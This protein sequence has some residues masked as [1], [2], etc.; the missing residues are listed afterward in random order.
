MKLLTDI[1]AVLAHART[2]PDVTPLEAQ[3]VL[4][5]LLG[6]ERSWIIAHPEA[7][8]TEDQ[9]S[10]AAAMLERLAQ[11]EPL[12]YLT[13]TRAFYGLDFAITPDVL[14][15]R[16]D[17]ETLVDA[18]LDWARQRSPSG[19]GL[20]LVDVGTGSGIIAIAMAVNLPDAHV[21]AADVSEAAVAVARGNGERHGVAHRMAFV[22]SDLLDAVD[23]PLDMVTA[24]LPYI[25]SPDLDERSVAKWEPVIGL[26]GGEDGLDLIR[27]LLKQIPGKLKPDGAL[28]LEIG[29][30]QGE[31][32]AR[33]CREAF[34]QA[35]V[36]V[37]A[38][39]AELD[40]VIIIDFSNH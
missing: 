26:D 20:R 30:D 24:N 25:A 39:L 13:G 40:R 10:E 6:Q 18:A 4:G 15:P 28:F 8:L 22:V 5:K 37:L 33:L 31:R 2:L 11:G 1:S 9:A 21:I 27:G 17:T 34:P 19:N 16:P 7:T 35:S 29:Y 36:E 38:D 23:G 14:V 32:G 12:A 3:L